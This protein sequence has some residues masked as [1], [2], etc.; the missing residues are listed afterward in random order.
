VHARSGN[1]VVLE[2]SE[3]PRP[4]V[5]GLLGPIARTVIGVETV[6]RIGI[7]DNLRGLARRLQRGLHCGEL[8]NGDAGIRT[9]VETE[10]S[11]V[12]TLHKINWIVRRH[13]VFRPL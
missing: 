5:P 8:S 2:P 4:A 3:H 13:I 6:G 12:D 7:D 11:R 1:A 10:D 9:A